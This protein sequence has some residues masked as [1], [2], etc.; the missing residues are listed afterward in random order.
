MREERVALTLI[1]FL[2]K[3]GVKCVF[4]CADHTDLPLLYDIKY[5][6]EIEGITTRRENQATFMA[7]AHWRMKRSPPRLL[8]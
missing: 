6:N 5:E 8:L 1:K 7:D 3:W 2:D 4:V